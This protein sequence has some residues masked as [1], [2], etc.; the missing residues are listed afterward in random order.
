MGGP[1][2][3]VTKG[4]KHGEVLHTRP[5]MSGLLAEKHVLHPLAGCVGKICWTTEK[6]VCLWL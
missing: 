4:S 1:S 5:H 6:C 2:F 3:G